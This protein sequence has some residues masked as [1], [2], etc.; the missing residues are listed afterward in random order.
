MT[1]RRSFWAC[2]GALLLGST[3]PCAAQAQVS[4][5]D[6]FAQARAYGVATANRVC[7]DR[8]LQPRFDAVDHHFNEV[9]N[10][11]ISEYGEA[12]VARAAVPVIVPDWPCQDASAAARALQGFEAAVADLDAALHASRTL[13]P[14]AYQSFL[15]A[16]RS[17]A[18][19]RL[20]AC[21]S[22]QLET[23]LA[24]ARDKLLQL[25]RRY[26]EGLPPSS[27]WATPPVS[28]ADATYDCSRADWDVGLL[29]STV[30]RFQGDLD[31]AIGARG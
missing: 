12:R 7:A 31:L 26:W 16:Y 6:L 25:T 14:M 29:E 8:S 2:L 4:V 22:P 23:R 24:A 21:S 28:T 15:A 1:S 17:L 5:F 11:L 3:T 10:R 27:P 18:G 19:I 9:I 13:E 30:E 20:Q